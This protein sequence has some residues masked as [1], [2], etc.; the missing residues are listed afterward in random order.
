M[1][2]ACVGFT[3]PGMIDDPGS[4]AGK[5]ISP[6]PHRGP[7]PKKRISFAIFIRATAKTFKKPNTHYN[8]EFQHRLIG[9]YQFFSDKKINNSNHINRV[10]SKKYKPRNH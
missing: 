2:S 3:F 8:L 6:N 9:Q 4:F 5:I 7:E 10:N 1:A